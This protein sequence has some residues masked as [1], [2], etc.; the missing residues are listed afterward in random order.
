MSKAAELAKIGEVAT[1]GQVSGRRNIVIN[2]A[3]NVAQ[4][5]TSETGKGD[6]SGYFTLDRYRISPTATAGR[7]TMAQVADGPAGFANCLKFTTTTADTSIAANEKLFLQQKFEGQDLQQLQKGT[8]TAKQFTVSFYVKGNAAAIYS[9]EI[10]DT[11]NNRINT[12]SFSVTTSWNRIELTFAG[13][14]TGALDDDNAESLDINIWL[15]GGSNF[16]SGTYVSNTWASTTDATRYAVANRTSIFDSTDR[17]FFITG[18]QME[19]GSVATPFEHRSY[20]EELAL[21]QRYFYKSENTDSDYKRYSVMFVESTV[22]TRSKYPL[23]I[24]MRDHPALTKTGTLAI[25]NS[26]G[27]IIDLTAI[28]LNPVF[29]QNAGLGFRDVCIFAVVGSGLTAGTVATLLSNNAA[30]SLQ[31]DAEL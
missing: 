5:S 19:V 24:P 16:T 30:A 15:H 18:L 29:T 12:Q 10:K 22:N 21:C 17:T 23:P 3:M 9:V 4:R 31:F 11:D 26:V 20:G 13:D 8:A 1:N 25:Y 14:T 6:A 7:I 28:S 27:G 2:G